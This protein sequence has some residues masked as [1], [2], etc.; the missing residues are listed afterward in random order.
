MSVKSK[1]SG[2]DALHKSKV[3]SK[4]ECK[5]LNLVKDAQQEEKS[6]SVKWSITRKTLNTEREAP[7]NESV[8]KLLL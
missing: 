6:W 2:K 1:I 5:R 3:I 4:V 8:N 7:K